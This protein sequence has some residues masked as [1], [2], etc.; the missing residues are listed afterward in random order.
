MSLFLPVLPVVVL[1]LAVAAYYIVTIVRKR[2]DSH[3]KTGKIRGRDRDST[4][5]EATRRLEQNPRDS[6]ALLSIGEISFNEGAFDVALK[7]YRS[8]VDLC[9]TNPHID[10]YFVTLRYGLSA[11]N[12]NRP[13][14]AYKSLLI[15]KTM[16]D[17]EFEVNYNLGAIEYQHK[18]YERAAQ[19]LTLATSREPEHLLAL[20]FLGHSLFK[21][22]RWEEA[23]PILR[24]VLDRSPDDKETLF[25]VARSYHELGQAE[26]A[27]KIFVH[28]RADPQVGASAALY[29]GTIHLQTR[30]YDQAVA[31]F[32]MGLKHPGVS[33]EVE[34][35]LKYRLAAT[36]IKREEIGEAIQLLQEI[37]AVSPSFR[38]VG[39]QLKHYGELNANQNLKTYL[40]SPTA[41]FVPLC[42]KL[43]VGFFPQAKVK[44][45]DISVQKSEYTDILASVGTAKWEDVILFRFV[46]TAGVVGELILRDL[47]S[48]IK[49]LKAGRGYCF[50]GGSFTEGAK[51][52]VE[53][54]LI[55][56]VEKDQLMDRLSSLDIRSPS[57][58]RA[59]VSRQPAGDTEGGSGEARA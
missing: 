6:D 10:E 56:L 12:S 33:G 40:L 28:L 2:T 16:K 34:L 50:A 24:R 30:Q 44:I 58:R 18:N 27:I 55:D 45:V 38:D 41:E 25:A 1:I 14:E 26:Q 35:E 31:D 3:Q 17:G 36:H 21:C 53:A 51:Q 4:F 9:A 43:I 11:L 13:E 46:R 15:A 19:L 22:K 52:F 23:A 5:R 57:E 29:A 59:D 39:E 7:T 37:A 20:R 49:E 32:E 8:L 48:R 42:R 47:N 54:R